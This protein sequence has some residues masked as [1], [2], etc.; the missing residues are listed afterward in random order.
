MELFN[1]FKQIPRRLILIVLVGFLLRVFVIVAHPRPLISDERDY[2]QLAVNLLSTGTYGFD[3]VPTAYRPIAYPALVS[4]VYAI[5]GAQP[6]AVKLLQALLDSL[7][8]LLLAQL[9]I[10]ESF[11]AAV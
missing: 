11:D 5:A 10:K 1:T 3:G 2:H 4:A 8:A 6:L 9:L 7:T